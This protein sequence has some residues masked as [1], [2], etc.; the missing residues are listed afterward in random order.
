MAFVQEDS[1]INFEQFK[2]KQTLNFIWFPFKH[3]MS[4]LLPSNAAEEKWADSQV[5]ETMP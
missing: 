5:E 3:T 1:E 2:T 4:K